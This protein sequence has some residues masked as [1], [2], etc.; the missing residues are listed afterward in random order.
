MG[1]EGQSIVLSF[2]ITED[3]PPVSVE[4]IRWEFTS[5]GATINITN[6][7]SSHY[8]L[9]EDRRNLTIQQLTIAQAGMYTL[10]ATNKAGERS[11]SIRLEVQ[12]EL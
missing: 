5:L 12:S 10:F 6:T 1:V 7:S 9:S 8:M 11:N 2:L 4:N 3:D